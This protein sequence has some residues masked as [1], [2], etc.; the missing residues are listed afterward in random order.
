MKNDYQNSLINEKLIF[1]KI[2]QNYP[3][4]VYWCL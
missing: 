4:A 3:P 2:W 1:E